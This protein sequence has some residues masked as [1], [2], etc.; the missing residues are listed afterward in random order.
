M[1]W[2][3]AYPGE[4]PTLGWSGLEWI[5]TNLIVPDGAADGEPLVFT[6]EQAAFVLRLYEVDRRFAGDPIRGRALVNARLV[7]RAVLSRCKGWGKS[8]VVAALCLL[9]ALGDVVP[10]GWDAEGR[11]VGR[12]WASLGFKPKVQIVAVSEDQTGNT[13]EPCL[14]M[15]RRGPVLDNYAIDPMDTFISVPRGVV[16]AVTSSARSREGFRP[17]F[18][19]LDQTESWTQSNGGRRLASTIRRNLGKVDGCSVETPNAF[20]PSDPPSVAEASFKA[21]TL[22]QEG[23]L[24]LDTGLLFDHREAPPETDPAD[25]TSLRVGLAY[26]LGES[27]DVNGGWVSL[28]RRLAEYWD[29]D[30]DPQDARRYYLNQV[31]HATD[32]WLSQPELLACRDLAKHVAPGDTITLGFDGSRKRS[33]SITDATALIGCRVSDGHL[34]ELGVW[35]Q[36]PG[37]LGKGWEVPRLQVDATVRNAFG[38]YH[39]V[40]MFC[41]P[42]KWESE[43]AG[44][45]AAFHE[46]LKVKATRDHPMQW[47]MTGGRSSLIV[48]V[49]G[50]LHEAVVQRLCSYDGSSALTRHL[51]NAR[52]RASRSGI[53]IAKA[54]PESPH[55]ID[56]AVAA[57]LAWA[58]RLDA[59]SK[60][61]AE[62]EPEPAGAYSF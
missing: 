8:P 54:Y 60:G 41:D 29:P 31:T 21:Y 55:K 61:L 62:A 51:L 42:A 15:A 53:Q 10:D 23:K 34:F 12:P 44:W 20:E 59:V 43:I 1:P 38:R 27:A 50:Q 5:R 9:E 35:E 17:V 28:D 16:E 4:R 7:R 3:P 58:A 49:T 22:Q 39:V 33:D 14:D 26:A 6:R 13:W 18:A 24:R 2:R 56:A 37:P 25:E 32:A 48:Q 52:R 47:W 30:T 57:I 45:E 11:P 36:P 19:A 40:G 46:K